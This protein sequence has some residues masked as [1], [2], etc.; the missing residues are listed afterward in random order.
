MYVGP[1]IAFPLVELIFYAAVYQEA[2]DLLLWS[3]LTNEF[4]SLQFN[5]LNF[6]CFHSFTILSV[7]NLNVPYSVNK[8]LN[9]NTMGDEW[10]FKNSGPLK[11]LVKFHGS[12]DVQYWA[13]HTYIHTFIPR[14]QGAFQWNILQTTINTIRL[15]LCEKNLKFTKKLKSNR[16]ERIVGFKVFSTR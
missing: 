10:S 7:F 14:P 16:S 11:S 4:I 6:Y 1:H 3:A 13:L 8:E 2:L 15:I 5:I 12:G 9:W